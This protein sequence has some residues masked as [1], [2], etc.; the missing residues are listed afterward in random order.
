MIEQL[1]EHY[2][3][4]YWL[5]NSVLL[6]AIAYV[7]AGFVVNFAIDRFVPL[8]EPRAPRTEAIKPQAPAS[9]SDYQIILSRNLLNVKV[10]DAPKPSAGGSEAVKPSIQATLLGTM[11]GPSKYAFA[12]VQVG[13]K[14]EVVRIGEKIANQAEVLEIQRGKVKIKDNGQEAWLN[15]YDKEVDVPSLA[16]PPAPPVPVEPP[17]PLALMPDNPAVAVPGGPDLQV[18]QVG[19]NAYNIDRTSFEAATSNL[20]PLL[21]QARVVPNFKN[22]VIDGYKV[23]AIKPDSLYQKIGLQNGDVIHSING[24]KIDSPEKALQLFQS[25]RTERTFNI[26]LSRNNEPMTFNYNLR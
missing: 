5:A 8:P 11:A 12:I 15:L 13:G 20:G 9:F 21:T 1:V 16:K 3:R 14:T 23:F 19:E 7:G 6:L 2:R 17:Q 25:L 22:G 26:D 10:E 24:V 4:Y 18:V